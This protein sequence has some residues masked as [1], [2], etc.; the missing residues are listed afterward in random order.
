MLGTYDGQTKK[1]GSNGTAPFSGLLGK[2]KPARYPR[3]GAAG[4]G[5]GGGGGAGQT[6]VAKIT[7]PSGQVCVGGG[8]GGGAST[9]GGGGGGG[10]AA[11][12]PKLKIRLASS[13]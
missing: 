12:A 2:L 8:G 9:G 3:S 4:G 7:E 1:G 5:G 10:G 11:G 6:S 13:E